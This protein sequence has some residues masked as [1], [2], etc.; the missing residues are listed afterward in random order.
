MTAP[1][2]DRRAG[3]LIPLFSSPSTASWGIGELG[4]VPIIAKWLNAAGL[5]VLQLLPLNEMAPGQQ[6]P[7]SAI[8]AMAIDPIF[9]SLRA[10]EDWSALGGDA[11]LS[12]DDRDSLESA[13]SQSTV[14]YR[15]IRR[16]KETALARC[17]ERFYETDWRLQSERAG[18]LKDFVQREQWW[19]EDYALFRAIRL[20]EGD[21]PW[22][23]WAESLR[24]R[25]PEALCASAADRAREIL[26]F[27]YVQWIA[28]EQWRSA[29]HAAAAVGVELFGD[30]PFM[31]DTDSADVW[32]HQQFFR[33]DVSVG[34]PPDAFSEDGQD[35][36]TPLYDWPAQTGTGFQ[37]LR[38]RARRNAD[39][40]DGYRVDHLVGFYRT[41][42]RPRNGDAPFFSP[43]K[44]PDQIALGEQLLK[45]FQEP[46]AC[47]IAEDLGTVPDFVR[48]SMTALGVP[49]FRVLRWERRWNE[50]GQPFEDP[51]DYPANSVA[52]SGT[53]DTEPL[54]VWWAASPESERRE[55]NA[56]ATIQRI[57]HGRGLLEEPYQPAVRDALLETL[58]ASGS[59]LLILPIQDV[60]GWTDRVNDPAIVSDTNWTVRLP[61]PADRLDHIP[62]AR[63]RLTQLRA[64]AEEYGRL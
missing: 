51:S 33:L 11:S 52:V 30:L 62:E 55:V 53:H 25:D 36:G 35:W 3:L 41:Y 45:L 14:A 29:R 10:Q 32:A 17:F 8:S 16:L 63:D 28:D 60:F 31:V 2:G 19:V 34:A 12:D 9:I 59:H 18:R 49:G 24:T 21:R 39:L 47:I 64:W 48:A 56:L 27:Q 6:S 50:P 57:T 20:A 38:S 44:E 13:R 1:V 37:W 61:W 5:R 58:F 26:F 4:D 22:T 43:D 7:Y 23:E 54:A 42:G 46:G 15:T 40:Y